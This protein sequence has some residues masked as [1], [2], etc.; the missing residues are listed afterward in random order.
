MR[1]SLLLAA[2]AARPLSV[3][4]KLVGADKPCTYC[5]GDGAL[6]MVASLEK[7]VARLCESA[8]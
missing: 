7:L 4:E 3:S 8:A 2:D 1:K 5:C 6:V